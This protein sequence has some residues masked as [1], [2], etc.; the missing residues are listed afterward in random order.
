MEREVETLRRSL[1]AHLRG[2]GRRLSQLSQEI[3]RG[4]GYL[5]KAL[6]GDNPLKVRDLF[7]VFT[8][9]GEDARPFFDRHY[10]L[11]GVDLAS[12]ALPPAVVD[13]I[14][15]SFQELL[16]SPRAQPP[17]LVPAEVEAAARKLL[18]HWIRQHGWTQRA[19]AE[20]LGW[21][22]PSLGG[23]LRGGTD[24]WVLH[25]F[26]I[27]QTLEVSPARFWSELLWPDDAGALRHDLVMVVERLLS[28][29]VR[30]D[31]FAQRPPATPPSRPP[32]RN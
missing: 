16:A 22:P 7:A 8:A 21:S 15:V 27:L 4:P 12:L 26:A 14:V 25:V 17:P 13:G 32:R 11:G 5:S 24:L 1:R 3:G 19:V 6:R 28:G 18:R 30:S 10:P 2:R 20:A 23:A 29:A 31:F 9:L